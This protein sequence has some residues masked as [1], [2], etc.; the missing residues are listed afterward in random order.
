MLAMVPPA[1]LLLAGPEDGNLGQISAYATLALGSAFALF[2]YPHTMTGILSASSRNV[3]RRN[4]AYLPAYSFMLGLLALTGFMSLA[5][6]VDKLPEIAPQ[7]AQYKSSFAV[8]ALIL[9]SFPDWFA[10]VA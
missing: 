7:F 6:G 10:W 1:K 9:H 5:V 3:I 2:L 8:P 4:A